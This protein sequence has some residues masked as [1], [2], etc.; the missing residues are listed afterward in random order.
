M[1]FLSRCCWDSLATWIGP[2]P[3]PEGSLYH[4][5]V[6]K[7]GLRM[8]QTALRVPLTDTWRSERACKD[9]DELWSRQFEM[10]RWASNLWTVCRSPLGR[11]GVQELLLHFL[12]KSYG[13]HTPPQLVMGVLGK[14][15][16]SQNKTKQNKE[17]KVNLS[18]S[19][20]QLWLPFSPY[21][22]IYPNVYTV[23][24]L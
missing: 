24:C 15:K 22:F 4:H 23:S 19:N 8:S 6:W 1:L 9:L 18:V 10:S 5:K 3:P 20:N 16:T 21:F 2:C 11:I 17:W 13:L 12:N 7:R 14:C